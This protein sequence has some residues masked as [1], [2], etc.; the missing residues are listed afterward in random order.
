MKIKE[1]K[2]GKVRD[3]KIIYIY[4]SFNG[5]IFDEWVL[6]SEENG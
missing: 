4:S 3:E 5:G 1:V 6:I 2:G